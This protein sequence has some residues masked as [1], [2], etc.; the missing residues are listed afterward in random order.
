MLMLVNLDIRHLKLV[1]V[2]ELGTPLFLRM[3][4]KMILP[5]PTSSTHHQSAKSVIGLGEE[6]APNP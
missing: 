6:V 5:A 1:A 3:N 2:T 4:K